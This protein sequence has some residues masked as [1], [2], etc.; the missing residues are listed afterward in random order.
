M[1]SLVSTTEI[2]SFTGDFKNLFDTFKREFVVVKQS[3]KRIL[4]PSIDIDFLY[5][6]YQSADQKPNTLVQYDPVTGI[7]QGIIRY[8]DGRAEFQNIGDLKSTVSERS[9][10]L[11]V[12][13]DAKE[14]IMKDKTEKFLIDEK[15][16]K[17]MGSY[18]VKYFFGV[19]LYVFNLEEIV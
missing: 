7:Y 1:P 6:G 11:K 14:F 18:A 12:E 8:T 2:E 15:S 4:A 9:V 19:K 16:F 5:H 17:L 13:S 3:N 10:R